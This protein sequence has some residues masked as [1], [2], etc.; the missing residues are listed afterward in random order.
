MFFHVAY[1]SVRS[2]ASTALYACFHSISQPVSLRNA[3]IGLAPHG[4]RVLEAAIAPQGGVPSASGWVGPLH[5]LQALDT[6]PGPVSLWC[7]HGIATAVLRQCYGI[8][9]V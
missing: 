3:K 9:T 4:L 5:A 8:A 2:Q 1:M 7:L 6:T